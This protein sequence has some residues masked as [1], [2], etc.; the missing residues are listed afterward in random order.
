MI[1]QLI[2]DLIELDAVGFV[3]HWIFDVWIRIDRMQAERD[4]EVEEVEEEM[5]TS[6]PES[7]WKWQIAFCYFGACNTAMNVNQVS[8]KVNAIN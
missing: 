8:V 5:S 3:V 4:V 2:I 1:W 7:K 6:S